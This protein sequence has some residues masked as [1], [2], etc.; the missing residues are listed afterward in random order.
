MNWNM[1]AN[2]K[3]KRMEEVILK[4]IAAFSNKYGGKLLIGVDDDSQVLGLDSD[5]QT[6]KE[7]NQDHFELH[8]RNLIN[9]NFG[10]DFAASQSEVSFA[11]VEGK[12]F[13]IVDVK[14][15]TAAKYI[16]ATTNNGPKR[17]SSMCEPEILLRN[18]Q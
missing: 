1:R 12:E 13:C 8:L 16:M 18:S 3:D 5:Y 17:E 6:F 9:A 14:R 7:V 15:G 10:K 4:T 2:Q 11:E